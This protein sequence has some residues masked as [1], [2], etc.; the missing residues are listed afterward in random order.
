ML[1]PIPAALMATAA[2]ASASIYQDSTRGRVEAPILAENLAIHHGQRVEMARE[3]AK[4]QLRDAKGK[5]K[6]HS[7]YDH[8]REVAT[9][10]L[11]VFANMG[12]WET[13]M[14]RLPNNELAVI[15][16]PGDAVGEV[17]KS[18]GPGKKSDWDVFVESIVGWA[19][20]RWGDEEDDKKYDKWVDGRG[21]KGKDAA[22]AGAGSG[23]HPGQSSSVKAAFGD[24]AQNDSV[25]VILASLEQNSQGNHRVGLVTQSPGKGFEIDGLTFKM[26]GKSV[27]V[28]VPAVV[29]TF[30]ED[31]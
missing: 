30:P 19:V 6:S 27:P 31:F 22:E 18:T 8:G 26:N 7:F 9:G 25:D 14:V 5:P 20:W 15:T 2:I 11:R 24:R 23:N 1:A 29:T 10:D 13:V 3:Q 21:P 12:D 17:E 28:G 4:A 16:W